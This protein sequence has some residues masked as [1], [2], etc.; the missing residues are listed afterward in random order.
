MNGAL[1]GPASRLDVE[2]V[3]W[4]VLWNA[5]VGIALVDRRLQVVRF[6]RALARM[7]GL[8]ARSWP[9]MPLA[10]MFPPGGETQELLWRI[11]QVLSTG[12]PFPWLELEWGRVSCHPLH[13][14]LEVVG[15]CLYVEELPEPMLAREAVRESETRL[16]CIVAALSEGIVVHDATG[17]VT[18]SN[19]AASRLLGLTQDQLLGRTSMDARWRAVKED[20]SPYPGDE[21][22]A[23]LALRMGTPQ[24]DKVMGVERPDGTRVWLSINALPLPGSDGQSPQGMV[25]SFFD[26]TQRKEAEAALRVSDERLRMSLASA[27]IG[28]WDYNP[29]TGEFLCDP[30]TLVLF[31]APPGHRMDCESFISIIHPEDRERTQQV[32]QR[33]L[34]PESG[35]GY[36]IE[37]RVIGIQDGAERWISAQGR[38]WFDEQGQLLR[39][40]GTVVDITQRKRAEASAR[41]LSEASG[42]LAERLDRAEELLERVARLAAS[43]ICTYCIIGVAQADGRLP[44]VAAAHREPSKEPLIQRSMRFVSKVPGTSPLLEGVHTGKS[45][46][47]REFTLAARQRYAVSPEHLELMNTLDAHSVMMVPMRAGGK[48]H[49]MMILAA[50]TPRRRFD[51]EDLTLAEELAHRVGMALENLRL[52]EEARQAVGL[53]DE[54][55]SVASHELK[56]PLTSLKLQHALIGKTLSPES[57]VSV[58]TRLPKAVRQVERLTSLVDS[59]LDVS[60]IGA[61]RLGLEPVEMELTGL[62]R[63]VMERLSE[64]FAQAGCQVDFPDTPPVHGY[65]DS[66][67]LDQVLVN[68][69]SNAAKY[70]AGK[71]IHVSVAVEGEWT[72]LMVRDEGIGIAPEHLPRLFSRF[73]RAVSERHYGGLGLGLFISKQIVEAMRGRILVESEPGRGS[74]F[75]VELPLRAGG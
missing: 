55:L 58:G 38:A 42:L 24:L 39:F 41:F 25:A 11:Q 7:H 33:T 15:L 40:N 47:I 51:E 4:E 2:A 30:R 3:Q 52:Y 35:G 63:E 17:A 72:R 12:Q 57:R 10:D 59:L 43:S 37:Y 21:H 26:I 14:G 8:H 32:I 56:T 44:R 62:L 18:F 1:E 68:L 19:E 20:G 48:V 74:T 60:R 29:A 69:L 27:T 50:C 23:M 9:G 53:R 64:V 34:R 61:G 70:G 36:D 31:G 73:G 65:W 13:E 54:F 45:T 16:R 71:P 67:R 5:P 22:P 75:T 46:L 49:G 66:L 6:N 28:T